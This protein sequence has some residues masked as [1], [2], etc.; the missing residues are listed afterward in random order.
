MQQSA[1]VKGQPTAMLPYILPFA[2]YLLLTQIPMKFPAYYPWLY[3]VCVGLVGLATIYLLRGKGIVQI[4]RN[5]LPGLLVGIGGIFLWIVLCNLQLEAAIMRHLPDWLQPQ[6]RAA[7]NPFQDIS[8]PLGQWSFIATRILG[9]A[10]LVP[11]AEEIFWRGFLLRW[12]ISPNWQKVEIGSYS[13][14]SFCWVV[15]LFTLAHPEWLAAIAYCSLLNLLL[16]WKRDLWNC[17][18]A[19]GVSNLILA[20]YVLATGAWQLW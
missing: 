2:L 3:G 20:I 18:V 9:M 8:N 7:F 15:L 16:Y 1:S 5:I 14:K 13:L 17:I 19:H 10:V 6:P 11:F 4:H 12:V